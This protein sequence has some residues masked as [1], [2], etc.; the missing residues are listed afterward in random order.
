MQLDEHLYTEPL[1]EQFGALWADHYALTM[2]QALFTDGRHNQHAIFHAYIRQNPFRGGY[3]ISAG[4]NI[5]F[6]WLRDHWRFDA[7][8]IALLRR[9]RITDPQSGMERPVFSD[10]FLEML[11]QARLALD[12]DSM[13]EGE[14]AFPHEPIMRVSGPLW[15]CLMVEAAI[16]NAINSQSLFATL[17]ARLVEAAGGTVIDFGLRRAQALAGLESTRGAWVGGIG[18]T[19]NMLAEKYYGIP[20][21]GT[22]A[23]ALVMA[24]EDELD[25]FRAYA[26]AMPGHCVFLVDTYDSEEGVRRAIRACKDTG[27]RLKGI[28]LDSGDLTYL[29]RRARTLLDEAGWRD[30]VIVASNDLDEETITA[31]RLEGA[32]IDIWGVGT[33]LATSRAQ[34]ALGA[35][36]KLGA[37]DGRPVIKLS[38]QPAK[39]TLP[40]KLDVVRYVLY[41]DGKKIR[42]DGD[43]I[44]GGDA[45]DFVGPDGRLVRAV[46]SIMKDDDS[47]VKIFAEG[48]HAYCPLQPVFRGGG[49]VSGLETIHQARARAAESLGLLHDTHRRLK[50]PHIY[51][52]G[53]D[54]GLYQ[55]RKR[56]IHDLRGV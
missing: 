26:G 40:G 33:S 10:A 36:Y 35:V 56:M 54:D 3:L 28:R 2:A 25:A 21:M 48:T 32:K 53:L 52:V 14:I 51:G 18:G 44:V 8:D 49:M 30:A 9:K 50:N 23:H 15:Q 45:S 27:A 5:I 24:Y 41:R 55:L 11:V 17:A 13:K 12:I 38:E 46:R 42:Y 47:R 29:S 39:V 34:P 31:V 37:V 16:L 7:A 1:C 19:S 22:F 6:Q 43:T 4:Q 20:A